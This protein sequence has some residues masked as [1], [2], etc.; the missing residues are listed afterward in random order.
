MSTN[1]RLCAE[2][3]ALKAT[4]RHGTEAEAMQWLGFNLAID[5]VLAILAVRAA[6]IDRGDTP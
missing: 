5:K 4:Q 6:I 1:D 2:I 3:E